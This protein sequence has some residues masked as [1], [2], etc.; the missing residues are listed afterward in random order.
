MYQINRFQIYNDQLNLIWPFLHDPDWY[1]LLCQYDEWWKGRKRTRKRKREG[2]KKET[3]KEK[4]M[5]TYQ[6]AGSFQFAYKQ[7]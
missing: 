7:E 1:S 2:K 6:G 4:K 5:R 3:E